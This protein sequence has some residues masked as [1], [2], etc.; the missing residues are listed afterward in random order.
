[1]K[2]F[3]FFQTIFGIKIITEN[4]VITIGESCPRNQ[5]YS[6]KSGVELSHEK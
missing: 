3:A 5:I 2:L 1:M 6:D 4:G